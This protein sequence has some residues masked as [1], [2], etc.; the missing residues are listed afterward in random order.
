MKRFAAAA[1]IFISAF[2]CFSEG[3]G[4]QKRFISGNIQ[5]KTQSVR[6]SSGSE[7]VLLAN[8]ALDFAIENKEILG[9]DREL[10]ALAL[11]GILAIPSDFMAK[12]SDS[13]K[14][15][16][17]DDFYTIY[18]IFSDE[19]VKISILRRLSVFRFSDGRFP[20]LLNDYLKTAEIKRQNDSLT[21]AVIAALASVGN[22]DS[23]VI[24]YL[25][26]DDPVWADYREDIKDSVAKLMENSIPQAIS[27]VQSGT[28]KDCRQILSLALK[29]EKFS[30]KIIA[31]IAENVLS[32]SINIYENSLS[33]SSELAEV[34]FDSFKVLVD[35]NWTRSSAAAMRFYSTA[36]KEYE[37]GFFPEDDLVWTIEN[38]SALDPMGSVEAF[39][40]YLSECNSLMENSISN[41]GAKKPEDKVVL[42]LISAL[43]AIGDKNAF[44]TLLAVTYY[45]YPDNIISKARDALASLKW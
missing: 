10:D 41:P 16:L 45:S 34:Q 18:N 44:D 42:A 20:S 33:K 4:N 5:D 21:K 40:S 6:S 15:K 24:L 2:L 17:S 37:E 23:F 3:T 19:N 12:A 25:L 36:K 8:L 14:K 7:A 38:L 13:E 1:F 22:S 9:D 29:N 27:I 32:R 43:G 26:C 11:S 28:E 30:N 31:E 39:S 35:L